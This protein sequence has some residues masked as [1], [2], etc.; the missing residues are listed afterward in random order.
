VLAVLLPFTLWVSG[1]PFAV[2]VAGVFTYRVLAMWLPVPMS[3]AVIP[4]L[5]AMGRRRQGLL[6]RRAAVRD[7]RGQRRPPGAA[8][9]GPPPVAP[10]AD[11]LVLREEPVPATPLP[12]QPAAQAPPAPPAAAS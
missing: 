9:C 3:I 12:G 4:T 8:P 6:L 11:A 2:A 10:V 1:A 5:R 7:S